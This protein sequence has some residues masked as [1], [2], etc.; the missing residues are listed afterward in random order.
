MQLEPLVAAFGT[1]K[2]P[3]LQHKKS[4][5]ALIYPIQNKMMEKV[6]RSVNF[7]MTWWTL[8]QKMVKGGWDEWWEV[9][10]TVDWNGYGDR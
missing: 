6:K 5:M 3:P 2:K 4:P 10:W 9:M 1:G 8:A 7:Y